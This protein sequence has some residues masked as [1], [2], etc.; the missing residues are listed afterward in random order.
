MI[1]FGRFLCASVLMTTLLFLAAS[2]PACTLFSLRGADGPVCGQN[3]D[4]SVGTGAVFVNPRGQD[5]QVG[6]QPAEPDFGARPGFV[7]TA[8]YGSLTFNMFGAGLPLGGMN[9]AGLVVAQA[10]YSPSVYP[11]PTG[12]ILNEFEWIQYALDNCAT[13]AE[14]LA[15]LN[16]ISIVPALAKLH[17]L[18]C[19]RDGDAAVVEFI[20]GRLVTYSG[21]DIP[22]PA[23]VNNSYASSLA[24]LAGHSGFGG[25]REFAG[26]VASPDRFVRVAESL[27]DTIAEASTPPAT[28]A[29]AILDSVRQHD[30]RWSIVYDQAVTAVMFRTDFFAGTAGIEL[31]DIDFDSDSMRLLRLDGIARAD[32]L[33]EFVDCTRDRNRRLLSD[34]LDGHV[35]AAEMTADQAAD[36]ERMLRTACSNKA[37]ENHARHGD[38]P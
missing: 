8:R 4:W 14:A 29:F 28:R 26:G 15:T 21:P 19:D 35:K 3:L 7:W 33:P 18:V 10:N 27:R 20:D 30:T 17:Y 37:H 31:L 9:E 1:T 2:S 22:V 25:D 32:R 11:S 36:A 23:L 12:L 5:R 24:Y 34:A 38:I 6:P 13:V 16:R